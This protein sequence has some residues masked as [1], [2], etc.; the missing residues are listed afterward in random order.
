MLR[1]PPVVEYALIATLFFSRRSPTAELMSTSRAGDSARKAGPYS[2]PFSAMVA[3]YQR[4][5]HRGVT[6]LVHACYT[7]NAG[8]TTRLLVPSNGALPKQ[9]NAKSSKCARITKH[10][11]TFARQETTTPWRDVLEIAPKR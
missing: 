2:V 8:W 3:A 6:A 11:L 1:P 5:E 4:E 9:Q 10:T 7:A